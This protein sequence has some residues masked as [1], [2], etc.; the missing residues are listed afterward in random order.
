MDSLIIKRIFEDRYTYLLFSLLVLIIVTPFV[1]YT[2]VFNVSLLSI[3]FL[4]VVIAI[5]WTLHLRPLLFRAYLATACVVFVLDLLT[6]TQVDEPST[7]M[8]LLSA[9]V[10]S[11]FVFAVMFALTIEIFRESKVTIKTIQGGI[12]VYLLIGIFWSLICLFLSILAPGSFSGNLDE[13]SD[14]LYF[15]FVTMTTLGYG[16]VVPL[17]KIAKNAAVFNAVSSQLFLA[18]YI[19]RL[20]GMHMANPA[21]KK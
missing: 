18:I 16:D 21:Q 14:Y 7:R 20:V 11:V 10:Y 5:L 9:G 8:T 2:T 19:A 3:F 6:S 1:E 12:S 15:S 17:T 13:Y 4:S